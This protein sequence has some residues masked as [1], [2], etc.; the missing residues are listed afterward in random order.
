[1]ASKY[2]YVETDG[3][4]DGETV[5]HRL[6]G[7]RGRPAQ[8]VKRG[9]KYVAVKDIKARAIK[10]AKTAAKTAAKVS[11]TPK[12][13]KATKASKTPEAPPAT[14]PTEVTPPVEA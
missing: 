3:K 1:M 13:K 9:G 14:P 11:K 8:F 6:N 4:F 10:D 12:A 7:G 5:F 2:N